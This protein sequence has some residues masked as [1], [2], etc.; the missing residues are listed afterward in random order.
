MARQKKEALEQGFPP[1][2]KKSKR[3]KKKSSTPFTLLFPEEKE[4]GPSLVTTLANYR[5]AH[6]SEF[7]HAQLPFGVMQNT[8]HSMGYK[9]IILSNGADDYRRVVAEVAMTIFDRQFEGQC[10]PREDW[11]SSWTGWT[12]VGSGEERKRSK[13]QA[14]S[15][16][17]GWGK[18]GFQSEG[19]KLHAELTRMIRSGCQPKHKDLDTTKRCAFSVPYNNLKCVLD[20]VV[21]AMGGEEAASLVIPGARPKANQARR[22]KGP[23]IALYLPQDVWIRMGPADGKRKIRLATCHTYCTLQFLGRR[24]LDHDLDRLLQ[25]LEKTGDDGDFS[26]KDTEIVNCK[27]AANAQGEEEHRPPWTWLGSFGGQLRD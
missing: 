22:D 19:E 26:M 17:R 23:T 8:P 5:Y 14:P 13:T 20:E 1:P 27:H 24:N 4:V 3:S 15:E 6:L 21:Q 18:W 11:S 16:R 10:L 9:L 2:Q 7:E 25:W 12:N